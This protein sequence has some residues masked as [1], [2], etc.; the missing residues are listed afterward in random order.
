MTASRWPE[1]PRLPEL[2]PGVLAQLADHIIERERIA[3]EQGYRTGYPAG[4]DVG[5]GKAHGEMERAWSAVAQYVR[6]YAS[7][8][9]FAELEVRRWG[10]GGRAHA[11]DPRPGDFPGWG[12]AG[13]DRR[14]VA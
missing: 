5:Y 1:L 2:P 10:P 7:V 13:L 9:A 12:Q 4:H 11:S 14:E 6:G 8:P 3:W